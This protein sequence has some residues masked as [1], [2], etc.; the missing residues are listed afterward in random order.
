MNTGMAKLTLTR[1]TAIPLS[2]GKIS[3]RLS[4]AITAKLCLVNSQVRENRE[5]MGDLLLLLAESSRKP[6]RQALDNLSRGAWRLAHGP[7]PLGTRNSAVG[8]DA[9]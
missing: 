2:T 1:M 8:G 9:P 6:R 3:N 5:N 4:A 7:W